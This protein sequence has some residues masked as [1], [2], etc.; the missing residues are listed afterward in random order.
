[1][2][3]TETV[4]IRLT[5]VP[6][7]IR[8]RYNFDANGTLSADHGAREGLGRLPS[9]FWDEFNI[10]SQAEDFYVV[11][12]Y[13]TPIAWLSQGTWHIPPLKY[14]VTTSKHMGYVMRGIRGEPQVVSVPCPF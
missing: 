14:S 5:S 4:R 9:D 12:S 11:R 8:G 13:N 2:T 7:H 3:T 10:C 6:A 1:M